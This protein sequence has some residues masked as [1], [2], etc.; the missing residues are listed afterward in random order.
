LHLIDEILYA[1]T[2]VKQTIYF[3]DVIENISETN[4]WRNTIFSIVETFFLI[5]N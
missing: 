1:H 4:F 5:H 2:L 3:T